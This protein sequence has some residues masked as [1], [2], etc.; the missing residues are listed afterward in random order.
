MFPPV[1]V[2]VWPWL[3]VSALLVVV[4]AD[5]CAASD[6][7][8]NGGPLSYGSDAT[9]DD[10]G[11][12][13]F[14]LGDASACR[15][16]DVGAYQP[17]PYHFAAEPWRGSCVIGGPSG[18]GQDRL[19]FD[20]CLA[21]DATPDGCAT[22]QSNVAN[23]ECAKCILTPDSA[24]THDGYGP[25]I[26]HGTFISTNVAGCLELTDPNALSCAKALQALGGCEL[27]ACEA[28]CPVHDQASRAAYDTCASHA[29]RVG[30]QSYETAAACVNGEVAAAPSC[31]LPT[32]AD[33]Y[34]AV[35]PLF[36]GVPPR[37]AGT[38]PDIDASVD[39]ISGAS[40]VPSTD[41]WGDAFMDVWTGAVADAKAADAIADARAADAT[42]D[43]RAAD[44]TADARAADAA[45]A[46][47]KAT[48]AAADAK[49]ADAGGEDA[50]D[51]PQD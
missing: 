50:E 25:L 30:C 20:R 35:V 32:F 41:A 40:V 24:P 7:A 37:D 29:D 12:S 19:F 2:A 5:G 43:A 3:L 28:N 8:G 44:A 15:P 17:G 38:F 46:D 45:V 26:N 48:D 31:L 16:G 14:P 13:T 42:A 22:F 51:A 4:G 49:S 33:F 39:A 10:G 21:P 11:A 23:A 9:S 18:N 47:A 27:R 6:L 1:R 36:C 34:Y